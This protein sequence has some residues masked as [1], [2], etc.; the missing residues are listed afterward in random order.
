[1]LVGSRPEAKKQSLVIC[2]W[3]LAVHS[4]HWPSCSH[5]PQLL[6]VR[7]LCAGSV[8]SRRM[9]VMQ[10]DNLCVL[11]NDQRPTTNDQRRSPHPVQL[12]TVRH[13]VTYVQKY[14]DFELALCA[15]RAVPSCCSQWPR[16][17]A[18]LLRPLSSRRQRR[19]RD[20]FAS[21]FQPDWVSPQVSCGCAKP[22]TTQRVLEKDN[23]KDNYPFGQTEHRLPK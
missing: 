12:S 3:S 9:R 13:P 16:S 18:G 8:S 22:G 19:I 4:C 15:A 7:L 23:D 20:H 14:R 10:A 21:E 1:M 2:P 6:C 5:S 11:A 17:L